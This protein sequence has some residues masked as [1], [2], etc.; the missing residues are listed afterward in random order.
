MR[1]SSLRK[2]SRWNARLIYTIN[3]NN[4]KNNN[5]NQDK[6]TKAFQKFLLSKIIL[7]IK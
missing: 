5:E 7:S 1:K 2:T 4:D 6:I 3:E